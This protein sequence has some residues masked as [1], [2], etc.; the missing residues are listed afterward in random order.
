[1]NV[2]IEM[3]GFYSIIYKNGKIRNQDISREI[4]YSSEGAQYTLVKAYKFLIYL[5]L[6]QPIENLSQEQKN[7]LVKEAGQSRV[8]CKML[9]V[10]N[11]INV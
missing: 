9:H 5:N 1:M 10:I 4:I 8:R 6:I 7:E 3:A 11:A 2:Y